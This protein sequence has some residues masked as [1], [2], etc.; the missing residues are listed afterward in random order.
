MPL[1][2]SDA[3]F[4]WAEQR[5][6]PMH[7]AGLQLYTAPAGS[8]DDHVQRLVES[9]RKHVTARTPFNLKPVFKVGHWF[10]EEDE[11]FELDYH[12]RHSA[13]PRPGRIRELLSLVSRLHG[14]LMDRSRPLWEL[15][16]IEGLAD[17]RVAA[18]VK[19]HHAMFDGMA[20]VKMLQ[21][22]LSED[23]EERRPPMWAQERKRREAPTDLVAAPREG[24]LLGSVLDAARLGAQILPGVGSGLRE[25]FR[26]S[27]QVDPVG[28]APFQAP[29]TI[30]NVP[31]S[32]SRRFAAQA[33]DLERIKALGRAAGATL[34]DITL[35]ICGG[36]LRHYLVARDALPDRPL[37]AMVPV[38]VRGDDGPA[39]GG[40]Q[41]SM[42]LA[43]LATHVADPL[44]RLRL[45]TESTTMGKQRLA[46]MTRVERLAYGAA[47][48]VSMGPALLTGYAKKRPMFNV[49]IS[50]VPGPKKPLHMN[51]MRL[52]E[53]Y[54]VSIPFDYLALNITINSYVDQLGFGYTA[55]RR[56]VPALQRMLGHTD[57]AVRELE[58]ALATRSTAASVAAPPK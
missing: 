29:P 39:E 4:L 2:P 15:H 17:G 49:V 27:S 43:N 44:E 46:G 51:G 13:L 52:E 32:G 12:L 1:S 48:G 16:L 20:A 45:V 8:W 53:M 41:V 22:V 35:A 28:A 55:C 7:V 42:M 26:G 34:N 3:F 11:D 31:I 25:V 50:N 23:A 24:G 19:V 36:A 30:F 37:V 38:S 56:A 10:W 18:Y 33:Y 14:A 47:M 5:R 6:Q 40:N 21:A 54:P 58:A 9:M 57:E